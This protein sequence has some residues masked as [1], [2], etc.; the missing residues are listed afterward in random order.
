MPS[1][2]VYLRVSTD[3]QLTDSQ[4]VSIEQYLGDDIAAWYIDRGVSGAARVKPSLT[5]LCADIE[6]GEISKVVVYRLDRLSRNAVEAL[7]MLFRWAE[8]D[9]EFVAVDQPVLS[10]TKDDPFRVTKLAMF[11]ELAQIE[12]ETLIR[13]TK[14]G[15][16][17]AR[18]RGSKL[19]A[20]AKLDDSLRQRVRE[21]R[22]AGAS[23][24]QLASE[25]NIATA[26]A[27]TIC[28]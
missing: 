5:R 26:T 11:A 2:A 20:P 10:A 7:R 18:A 12:R 23:Y 3:E 17:A 9:V 8:Q 21:R 19:G 6:A 14:A 22:K 13:R 25:F 1:T 27:H 28:R 4:R 15:L 16:V 24:R